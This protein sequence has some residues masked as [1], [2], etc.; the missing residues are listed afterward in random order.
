MK[1]E[2]VALVITDPEEIENFY[3][4]ILGM[5]KL[6]NFTVDRALARRIFGIDKETPIC[7]LQKNEL[8]LE[9]FI[10]PVPYE[11]GFQ[12]I[13]IS[14]PDREGFVEQAVQKGYECIRLKR[15]HSDLVFIKDGSGNIFEIKE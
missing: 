8:L 7:L 15:T 2:H 1:L 6:K 11:R 3:Q 5:T 10:R 4:N 13:C 12:H 14:I 9:L